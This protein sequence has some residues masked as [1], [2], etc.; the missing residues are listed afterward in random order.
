M[1]GPLK[2]FI[3]CRRKLAQMREVE[4]PHSSIPVNVADARNTAVPKCPQKPVEGEHASN[5]GV[6]A[7]LF[8]EI[9][10]APVAPGSSDHT[11]QHKHA[12]LAASAC[13]PHIESSVH[14]KGPWMASEVMERLSP[15]FQTVNS[16]SKHLG[17]AFV[18]T[19]ELE[20]L[21]GKLK[22]ARPALVADYK[23]KQRTVTKK[24][25]VTHSTTKVDQRMWH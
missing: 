5:R 14:P 3:R 17:E 21:E 4:A 19:E 15:L 9:P 18:R 10:F 20:V 2:K 22:A 1:V 13:T 7:A 11:R 8:A 24:A 16:H 23:S 25:R 6:T 12:S